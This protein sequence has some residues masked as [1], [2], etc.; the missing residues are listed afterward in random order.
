MY[1]L[2]ILAIALGSSIIVFIHLVDGV[3]NRRNTHS[4]L[5]FEMQ[6]GIVSTIFWVWMYYLS[7]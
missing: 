6:M 5:V 3:A 2:I 7:H 1:P 4:E